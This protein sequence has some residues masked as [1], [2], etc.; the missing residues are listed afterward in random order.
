MRLTAMLLTSCLILA[1]CTTVSVSRD[2][3]SDTKKTESVPGIPFYVK[4]VKARHETKWSETTYDV[5]VK[6]TAT[7][8]DGKPKP[9]FSWTS[10]TV[11]VTETLLLDDKMTDLRMAV[12]QFI[13]K[14]TLPKDDVAAAIRVLS[15]DFEAV[16]RAANA[17]RV[18]R[19]NGLPAEADVKLVS[20]K[21]TE[22]IVVDTTIKYYANG[23]HPLIGTGK[24]NFELSKDMT[25]TK[26]ETEVSDETLV[27]FLDLLPVEEFFTKQWA[28]TGQ[29]D[30]AG[31]AEPTGITIMA[32]L[33]VTPKAIIYTL[34]KDAN[35]V[36]T[37]IPIA[38]ATADGI[39][40]EV[41]VIKPSGS[42]D[43]K[44]D[45]KNTVKVD[46]TVKLPAASGDKK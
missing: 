44:K 14:S 28:L 46:A 19:A 38:N 6:V 45:D 36:G 10:P 27:T 7:D 1:S 39:S 24:A 30:S 15:R 37:I 35:T 4:K 26:V 23:R 33:K 25:L 34:W 31:D 11:N 40:F 16:A 42:S 8:K 18:A 5:F 22:E 12:S 21:L 9:R 41:S 17:E 13:K 32:S 2:K 20:N 43:K 29:P 3:E